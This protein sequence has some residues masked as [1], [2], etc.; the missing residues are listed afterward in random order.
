MMHVVLARWLL[1]LLCGAQGVGTLAIDLNRTHAANPLWP[2]HARFHLVWQAVSYA[3]LSLLETALILAPGPFQEQRFY[4][5]AA[6]AAIPMLSCLAAFFFGR[7]YGG[8]IVNPDGISPIRVVIRGAELHIDLNLAAE[9]LALF[10]LFGTLVL[11][12][13]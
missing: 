2:R 4:L 1:V 9:V 6:L 11:F 10:I 13:R 8:S 7:M 12:N 3:L 5:A